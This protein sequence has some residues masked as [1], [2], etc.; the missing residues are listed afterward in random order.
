MH[1]RLEGAGK[2]VKRRGI[3]MHIASLSTEFGIGDFGPSAR[4]FGHYLAESGYS[5]WQILPLNHCGYGNS[6]YNPVS[7]FALYPA[8]VSPELLYEDGLL[9]A[10]DLDAYRLPQS[11]IIHYDQVI[12]SKEELLAIATVNFLEKHDISSFISQ[13][14]YWLKPYMCFVQLNRLYGDCA[15][16]NYASN[17]QSY[18][19]DLYDSLMTSFPTAMYQIAATQMILHRQLLS[20]KA[21]LHSIN[22]TLMGDMPIYL[23]YHSAEVWAHR[24]LFLM[25]DSGKRQAV[26]GVPPDAFSEDGQLW[27]NPIYRWAEA[28][29]GVFDLFERR[30]GHAL[31][32]L[33][34]LRLDHFIGYVNYWQVPCPID[35]DTTEPVMP[36]HA[37]DGSWIP[38]PANDFFQGITTRF[39]RD[40]FI[41]EDLG[42][43]ND[44]VCRI[45]EQYA[46]PGMIVLQFCFHDSVPDVSA[47]PVDRIVY[48]GTHDNPTSR[49][50]FEALPR[51]G[52]EYQHFVQYVRQH[53]ELWVGISD[54]SDIEVLDGEDAAGLMIAIAMQS[55]CDTVIVPMQ[56]ILGLGASARMNVPGTALGNWQWR[57]VESI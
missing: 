15:W 40:R 44:A 43:L 46:F 50:W 23:S 9:T 11:D 31:E 45:R 1:L 49:E 54:N 57:M 16:E 47:Y 35:P 21:F 52:I 27:G 29:A 33:D 25:D 36:D 26:A 17:H 30:I 56:D 37:R 4:E 24:E 51:D 5:I 18:R 41:A 38:A 3:L 55:G 13:N 48:T 39:G 42:I 7:A 53:P 19:E 32:C 34:V 8:L 22:V 28:Q 14:E 12:K 10:K 2:K 20:L 6:P